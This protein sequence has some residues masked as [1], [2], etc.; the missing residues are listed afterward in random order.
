M[1]KILIIFITIVSATSYSQIINIKDNGTV[2]NAYGQYYKDIDHLLDPF[3]GT[4]LYENGNVSLKIILKTRINHSNGMYS[5]DYIRGG[6]EYKVNNVTLINTLNDATEV[7]T[8]KLKYSIIGNSIL[9]NNDFPKCFDCLPNEYRLA[10]MMFCNTNN[11]AG[12]MFVR[13]I[14]VNGQEALKIKT[15]ADGV[16]Q[17]ANG[18]ILPTDFVVPSGEYILIKQ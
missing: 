14:M 3:E 6:Y 18:P 8:S 16:L 10:L 12:D 2:E 7:Y 11:I 9:D 4:W 5:W 17:D 15:E 1:K 13:K